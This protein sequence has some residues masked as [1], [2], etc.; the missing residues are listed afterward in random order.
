MTDSTRDYFETLARVLLR[1]W[2][3][4][5]LLLLFSFGMSML[6]GDFVHQVHGTMFGLSPHEVDLIMYCWM[7]LL[8][9]FVFVF[10]LFP[11]VAIRLVLRKETE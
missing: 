4:G 11:W 6:M 5:F 3:I 10:F 1:C 8:K 2:I 7:G 9:L